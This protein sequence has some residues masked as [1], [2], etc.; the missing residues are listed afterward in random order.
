MKATPLIQSIL[1]I[2]DPDHLPVEALEKLIKNKE[3]STPLLLAV[4]K[5]VLDDYK[6]VD[7]ARIDFIFALSILSQFREKEAFPSVIRFALLPADCYEILL[8]ESGTDSLASWIVST[9]NG[10]LNAIKKIIETESACEEAR[11]AAL[12][13]LVGLVAIGKLSRE[14]V[15]DYLHELIHSS[16]ISDYD[17]TCWLVMTIDDLYPE[18]LYEC[19]KELYEADRFDTRI[20]TLED[21]DANLKSGKEICL[22]NVYS[23]KFHLPITDI[24]E[25]LALF[26]FDLYESSLDDSSRSIEQK[27]PLPTKRR[28]YS[29][30]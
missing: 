6:R 7:P 27:E 5:E 2:Y 28:Q 29:E 23:D 14:D 20:V 4:L 8:R 9:Y 30:H 3:E 10:D 13:S 15:V 17:F 21:I 25:H 26:N 1:D 19:I 18:E 24:F 16:L 12:S 22:L 11:S